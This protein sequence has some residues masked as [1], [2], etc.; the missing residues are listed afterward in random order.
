MFELSPTT[1]GGWAETLLH[2]FNPFASEGGSSLNVYGTTFT[3]GAGG[4]NCGGATCG[5]VFQWAA[6]SPGEWTLTT[7]HSFGTG[8]DGQRPESVTPIIDSSGNLYST[9]S[10]GGGY[11]YGAVFGLSPNT[12]GIWTETLL[13]SFGL[14][15]DGQSPAAG[16]I[17]DAGGNL[18][19]TTVD[20]GAG[21]GGIAFEIAH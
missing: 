12:G 4:F 7:P 18:Y 1:G 16:L 10:A 17:F 14:G 19:G 5:T 11:G 20:G 21:G 8:T 2:S 9:T 13:H 15:K 3:G 6:G